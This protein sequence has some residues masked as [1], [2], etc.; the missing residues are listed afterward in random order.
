MFAQVITGRVTDIDALRR[1]V[2]RWQ[3]DLRPGA[4][5]YLGTTS[6]VSD[7]SKVVVMVRFESEADARRNSDR[8]EQG[9]W[10]AETERYLSDVEFHESSELNTQLGGGSDDAGFVQVMRGRITDPG[11]YARYMEQ[12]DTFEA[13]MKEL[14]PDILGVV[15]VRLPDDRYFD[16]AY[17]SSEAAAR[18]GEAKEMPAET[19]A[20]MEE[21]M[22]AAPVDEF[23]D[24]KDPWLH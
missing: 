6:G 17:F 5:G 8:P 12:Q 18:I 24:L 2:Q 11:T 3:Q 15:S 9:V 10:W 7:D 14:R 22:G 21:M 4:T 13:T 1:Q 19:Q 23:F 16:F 20:Q